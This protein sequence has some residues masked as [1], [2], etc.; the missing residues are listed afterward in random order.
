MCQTT[1]NVN[2]MECLNI[3]AV[4]VSHLHIFTTKKNT[5][6][7]FPTHQ[8][9][10]ANF[11]NSR[12]A[13]VSR[14]TRGAG[15]RVILPPLLTQQRRVVEIHGRRQSKVRN[16]KVQMSVCLKK[17]GQM[18]GRGQPKSDKVQD[19]I[20]RDPGEKGENF[21]AVILSQEALSQCRIR[22]GVQWCYFHLPV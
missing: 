7:Y 20:M 2:N 11:L 4:F 14:R 16:R 9:G 22:R 10:M 3:Y 18:W 6:D 19:L 8:N 15:G 17:I 5:K 12:G 13:G 21:K 1:Y